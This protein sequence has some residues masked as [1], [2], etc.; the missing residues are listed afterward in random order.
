MMSSPASV[1]SAAIDRENPWPGLASFTEDARGFFYGREKE[2][3]E[4]TRLVKRQTL[5]VLF[6]QSGLGKS[7]LLQAGLFPILRESDH[8]PL[9]LRLD[10]GMPELPTAD[11]QLPNGKAPAPASSIGHR[12]SE[13]GNSLA[14]QV[15]AALTAE[16]AAAKAEAPAFSADETLWEYFHRKD[17]D[18]WSAKNRLLTP[19]LAFDQFEEIFTLG[20]ADDVRRERSR[21]F[22]AELACLVENRPPPAVREKLDAGV[23]DPLRFNYDKPSCQVILSL[24]EDFLPDLEGLKQ[25]MPALVHNRLRLKRLSGTQALEIVTRPAPQ[26]LAEGVAERIVE[27]VSGGRGGSAERLAELEVEPALLSVICREL[28]ERRRTLG[29]AQITAEQVSGNR[30]EILTDF[31]ERSVAD[32]PEGMRAFVEDHLLTKSGFRDNLALETALEFPGVTRPLIDTLVSRRLL[33][34]EDRLGV[35]RVELTHDVLAEAIRA[36]RDSRQQLIALDQAA[37]RE[38]QA[39]AE[40][41]RRTRRMRFAIGGLTL[42]VVALSIGAVFGLRAQRRAEAAARAEAAQSS[43]TDLILGS[44]L[45]EEN[46]T[47]EGLAYLVRAAESD[48]MNPLVGSRLIAALAYRSFAEPVGGPLVHSVAAH[49]GM[50]AE[51]LGDGQHAFTVDDGVM[52]YWNLERGTNERSM[53]IDAEAARDVSAKGW[54]ALR[55]RDGS[56]TVKDVA[57]GKNILGPL[58][59]EQLISE[60]TLSPDHR[61]VVTASRADRTV[62]IWDTRSGECHATVQSPSPF[63]GRSL[64]ISPDGTRLVICAE[65][66]FQILRLPEGTPLTPLLKTGSPSGGAEYPGFSP[67]GTR[68]MLADFAGGGQ[69]FDGFT[70]APVSEQFLQ[71]AEISVGWRPRSFSPDGG[72]LATSGLDGTVRIWDAASGKPLGNPLL[73]GSDVTDPQFLAGGS[74]L[75]T[76]SGA[77]LAQVWNVATH[78]PAVEPISTGDISWVHVHP[79]RPEIMTGSRDGVAR[80]W[81]VLPGAARPMELEGNPNRRWLRSNLGDTVV[82]A[83]SPDKIERIDILTGAPVGAP[84]KSPTAM[85]EQVGSPDGRLMAGRIDEQTWELWDFSTAEIVRKPLGQFTDPTVVRFSPDSSH[86]ATSG[87]GAV[88]IWNTKTGELAMDPIPNARIV[89][90]HDARAFSASGRLLATVTTNNAIVIVDLAARRLRAPLVQTGTGFAAGFSP[91]ERMLAVVSSFGVQLWNLDT[92]TELGERLPHR[93]VTRG[94]VFTRDGSRLLT[95]TRTET[96]LWDVATRTLMLPPLVGG[97]NINHATFS[98]DETRIATLAQ[99]RGEIRVWDAASGSLMGE[100]VSGALSSFQNLIGFTADGRFLI[101]LKPGT[102]PGL[103]VWPVPPAVAG[104]PVPK[105]LVQL[106][107]ARAGGAIDPR[108]ALVTQPFNEK[109]FAEVRAELAALPKDAPYAEWGRWILADR[110][111]RLIGPGFTVTAAEM[112]KRQREAAAQTAPTAAPK[113]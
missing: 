78:T 58:R 107:A 28:N 6:G 25:E 75:V 81:S 17:V 12:Q 94:A 48:A 10:H 37:A 13:I 71:G 73:H 88:R 84:W 86:L 55:S 27:F 67:D 77:G 100:P 99:T 108:G 61:W 79:T 76:R 102:P 90:L 33:R 52:N 111:T 74:L 109:V 20:R 44:R 56:V 93:N 72:M 14:D 23:L 41:A 19:V 35:Q 113:R 32:L 31:Y 96:N 91:D 24:R 21:A 106:A 2:T 82:W 18:I 103:Q 57:S 15:K 47:R 5:T 70:G 85:L 68:L 63:R 39:R 26:L 104:Q 54:V 11:R 34:I 98:P 112:E 101:A 89:G 69:V 110:A 60:A 46:K 9:Y 29:Q 59:H 45:L 16:F 65:G 30:R 62:K 95:W 3:E 92:G 66:G 80:R 83:I 87:S 53:T 8:L 36:S 42:A 7:S 40:A 49:R 43:R 22:L 38:R 4:L 51:Y 97:T 64:S 50:G 105:W 1:P